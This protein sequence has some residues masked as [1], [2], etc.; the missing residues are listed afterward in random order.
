MDANRVLQFGLVKLPIGLLVLF[1][2][3]SVAVF[4]TEKIARK[5]QLAKDE[6]TNIIFTLSLVFLI[7][8]KFGWVIFDI[9]SVLK[10]PAS[11]IW[12][13][14]SPTT[15]L[16]STV[17]SALVFLYLIKKHKYPLFTILD[18]SWLTIA[19]T[20]FLY[21]LFIVDYGKVTDLFFGIALQEG[22]KFNYHPINWYRVLWVGILLIVRFTKWS[23]LNYAKLL[24]LYILLGLGLLLISIFDISFNLVFGFTFN[25]WA[26]LALIT[27]GG[28]GLIKTSVD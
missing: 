22:S 18:L 3:L 19:I 24:Y 23:D 20:L 5:K 10:N 9:K 7:F 12:T 13:T 21:N 26:F 6:W 17:V 25:Q 28:V 1:V 15:I 27:L 16:I 2:G 14:G 8:Y 4:I 11:L